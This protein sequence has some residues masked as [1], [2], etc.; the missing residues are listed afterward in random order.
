MANSTCP[1]T[2]HSPHGNKHAYMPLQGCFGRTLASMDELWAASAA[3]KAHGLGKLEHLCQAAAPLSPAAGTGLPTNEAHAGTCHASQP[4]SSVEA[5]KAAWQSSKAA[6]AAPP[7]QVP[8]AG[9]AH[10]P[11]GPESV[12]NSAA[13]ASTGDSL[14]GTSATTT[15]A[16]RPFHVLPA[17]D[18]A[19]PQAHEQEGADGHGDGSWQQPAGE[20][21]QGGSKTCDR[22]TGEAGGGLYSQSN[23]FISRDAAGFMLQPGREGQRAVAGA[24][25]GGQVAAGHENDEFEEDEF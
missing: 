8:P 2:L 11:A 14:S 7:A 17:G 15:P 5:R 18:M 13:T 20:G 23:P 25:M 16:M 1:F 10:E 3:F 19:A 9:P 4:E 12:L 24:D 22:D 6:G 21:L